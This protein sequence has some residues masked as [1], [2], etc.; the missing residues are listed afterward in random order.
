MEQRR[1]KQEKRLFNG[2]ENATQPKSQG[3]LEILDLRAHYTALQV[4]HLHKFYN[5][6]DIPWVQLTWNAFYSRP[7]SPYHRKKVGS[8]WWRDIISLSDHTLYF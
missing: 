5:K 3:G 2:L 7:I 4:K 8:F 1:Y 6:K